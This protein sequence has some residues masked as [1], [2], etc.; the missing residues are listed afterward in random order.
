MTRGS[1]VHHIVDVVLSKKPVHQFAV[2]N[3]APYKEAATLVD[4]GFNGA[5][6]AGVG[7]QVEHNDAEVFIPVLLIEQTLDVVGTDES[8]GSCY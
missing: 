2:A 8:G 3:V 6:V 1:E 7:E 4:V 5:E